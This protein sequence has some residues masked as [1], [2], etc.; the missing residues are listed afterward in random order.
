MTAL[1]VLFIGGSGVISSA[2]S[3]W[4]QITTILANVAGVQPEIVQVPSDAIAAADPAWGEALLGDRAHSMIFDNSKLRGVLP[5]YAASITLEQAARE[6]VDWHDGDSDRQQ[7]DGGLN[8][9][10]DQLAEQLGVVSN[11]QVS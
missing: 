11:H 10:M 8:M 6:I 5:D 1:R 9:V 4:N 2:C 7:V 3:Q